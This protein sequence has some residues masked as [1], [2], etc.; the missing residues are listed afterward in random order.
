[1]EIYAICIV[2]LVI[3][4]ILLTTVI[5]KQ[6]KLKQIQ[7]QNQAIDYIINRMRRNVAPQDKDKLENIINLVRER[8]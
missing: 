1:M 4:I 6:H 8:G 3:A 7:K 5:V 2:L